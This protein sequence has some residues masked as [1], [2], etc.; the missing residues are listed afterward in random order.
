MAGIGP[1]SGT[2]TRHHNVLPD[3]T[4]GCG[5]V[6]PAGIF[7][8]HR[9]NSPRARPAVSAAK[10]DRRQHAIA[11]HGVHLRLAHQNQ[12]S[13]PAPSITQ[14]PRCVFS[15]ASKVVERGEKDEGHGR[16]IFRIILPLQVRRSRTPEG[17]PERINGGRKRR[18]RR[19]LA[20]CF[21][22]DSHRR[23]MPDVIVSFDQKPQ[24]VVGNMIVMSIINPAS[25]AACALICR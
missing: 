6:M 3:N 22:I 2:L 15:A 12:A 19:R 5:R 1:Y 23:L 16:C 25:D 17:V 13:R 18:Y 21:V 20:G 4:D 24:T 7:T 14:Q 9:G 8:G 11:S 10:R